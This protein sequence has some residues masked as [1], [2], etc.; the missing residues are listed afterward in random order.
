M[1]SGQL[2]HSE[3]KTDVILIQ[4]RKRAGNFTI[5]LSVFP[6]SENWIGGTIVAEAIGY[7]KIANS[8]GIL[9]YLG[10]EIEARDEVQRT[11]RVYP[12]S[13]PINAP[14]NNARA[15]NDQYSSPD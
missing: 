7:S 1:A 8:K 14:T 2:L 5:P 10:E 11:Q 12:S 15:R 13:R 3:T 4:L 6:I 9:D